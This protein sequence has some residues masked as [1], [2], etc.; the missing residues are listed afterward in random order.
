MKS[1]H[2]FL[3]IFFVLASAAVCSAPVLSQVDEIETQFKQVSAEEDKR[4]RA[5]L[6]EPIPD[7][8]T[9]DVLRKHFN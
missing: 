8:A 5:I 7:G 2:K 6:A 1:R 4:L 9:Q 3:Q